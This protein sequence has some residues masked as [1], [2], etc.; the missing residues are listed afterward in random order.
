[1]S[2]VVG[3]SQLNRGIQG[4]SSAGGSETPKLIELKPSF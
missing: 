3:Y 4:F 1:V 2:I